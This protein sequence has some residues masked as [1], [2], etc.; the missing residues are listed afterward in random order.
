MSTYE[1]KAM[2]ELNAWKKKMDRKPSFISHT[3]KNLQTK[4]NSLIPEKAHKVITNAIKNMVK[5]ILFGSEFVTGRPLLMSSL[6]ER[7]RL[8]AEKAKF[9]KKV[10][11][12]SGAWTGAGGLL[13][14]LADFPILLSLKIK[15]LFDTAVLYGFD[16]TDYKERLYILHIFQLAFSS[17]EKRREVYYKILDWN[18][19]VKELP[20]TM[21]SFDW[22]IFQQ[23]YRDY[24]DLAKMLQLIPGIGAVIGAYANYQLID[25]LAET[26]INA[27]RLRVINID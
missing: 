7:E 18:K 13:L 9:Y 5:V 16:T 22:K 26:A 12:T 25:R 8:V 10:A 19:T 3:T 14:G 27:Y 4:A 17:Q 15:F 21:E 20:N 24:I 1:E 23:E 11:A 2:Y 6:E